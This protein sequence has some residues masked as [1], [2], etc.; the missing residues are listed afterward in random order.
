MH[1]CKTEQ[2]GEKAYSQRGFSL[3]ELAGVLAVLA[4]LAAVLAPALLKQ[5]DKVVADQEAATLQSFGD[6]LQRSILRSSPHYI[7]CETNWAATIAGELGLNISDVLTN[8]RHQARVF[9]IDTSGW[10][11]NVPPSASYIQYSS[12][13][14]ALPI[15]ARLMI[16]SA[17]GSKSVPLTSGRTN[18]TYFSDLWTTPPGTLP[19]AT[20]WNNWK[21]SPNDV[22]I[23]RINLSSLFVSLSLSTIQSSQGAYYAI[24]QSTNLNP[25]TSITN[26]FL[27]NSLL[28]LDRKSTRLNSSH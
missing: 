19:S 4:I 25:V 10:F 27:K 16:L 18:A 26:Y 7:P 11:T 13:T 23:Q 17:L 28:K 9:L 6:A 5:T 20:P 12:G 24:D 22:I 3:I 2:S 8:S 21:E 14:P 15:N 1:N